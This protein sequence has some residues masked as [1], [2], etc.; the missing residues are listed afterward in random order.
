MESIPDGK[1]RTNRD[2]STGD[3]VRLMSASGL[4]EGCRSLPVLTATERT[5]VDA[6]VSALVLAGFCVVL[7]PVSLVSTQGP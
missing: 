6:L 1:Y 2:G 7:Y 3:L 4:N 5:P